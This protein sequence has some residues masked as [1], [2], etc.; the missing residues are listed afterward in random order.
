MLWDQVAIGVFV[1]AVAWRV[2]ARIFGALFL[3][4]ARRSPTMLRWLEDDERKDEP[5]RA[6]LRR[7]RGR[8]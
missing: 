2:A 8:A 6:A 1:G 5:L 7:G 3:V 4:L